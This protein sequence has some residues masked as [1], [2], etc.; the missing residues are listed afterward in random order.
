M[1]FFGKIEYSLWTNSRY[2]NSM[3]NFHQQRKVSN[4]PPKLCAFGPKMKKIVGFFDKNLSGSW[5][6]HILTKYFWDFCL[7]SEIIY[8]WKMTSVFYNNFSD[9]EG[10]RLSGS[11][12]LKIYEKSH[13]SF[14]PIKFLIGFKILLKL[15]NFCSDISQAWKMKNRNFTKQ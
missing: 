2:Q 7:F 3:N 12:L 6:F 11:G 10:F 14:E 4:L 9:F 5:L 1:K 8:Q 13:S 15:Q